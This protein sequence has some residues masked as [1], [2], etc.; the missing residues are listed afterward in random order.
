MTQ[1]TIR[2]WIK[3]SGLPQPPDWMCKDPPHHG[4]CIFCSM[5]LECLPPASSPNHISLIFKTVAHSHSLVHT[6][7]S[8]GLSSVYSHTRAIILLHELQPS[9]SHPYIYSPFMPPHFISS[10]WSSAQHIAAQQLLMT[11]RITSGSSYEKK[12]KGKFPKDPSHRLDLL[13]LIKYYNL[14]RPI[15]ILSSG[16]FVTLFH[17]CPPP[18]PL[19]IR[20]YF[21]SLTWFFMSTFLLFF[22]LVL[23]YTLHTVIPIFSIYTSRSFYKLCNCVTT[24]QSRHRPIA[25]FI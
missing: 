11:I 17:P 12:K 19:Y 22:S 25:L 4:L 10:I 18:F 16:F 6:R 5:C 15:L 14:L 7:K 20:K 2:H 13:S 1:K 9:W 23:R 21:V 24:T 3:C 8:I